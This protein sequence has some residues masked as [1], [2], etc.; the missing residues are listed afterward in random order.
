MDKSLYKNIW[1]YVEQSKGTIEKVSLE[2]LSEARKIADAAGEK[3]VGLLLGNDINAAAEAVCEMGVDEV[4]V[5]EGAEYEPYS[6]DAYTF[7]FAQLC[8]KYK[9]SVL[10]LG[11]TDNGK[12]FAP[13][14]A[15]RGSIREPL[16]IPWSCITILKQRMW[17]GPNPPLAAT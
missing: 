11:A 5:V 7:A 13:R 16:P 8:K 2:L 12:D 1:V 6:T 9:P 10:F 17:N 4:I 15:C 3:L 14:L